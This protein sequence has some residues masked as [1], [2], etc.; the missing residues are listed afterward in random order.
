MISLAS[1]LERIP[2]FFCKAKCLLAYCTT[3]HLPNTYKESKYIF[4]IDIEEQ[5]RIT[6][7]LESFDVEIENKELKIET[8]QRLKNH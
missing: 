3:S 6:M 5:K 8:L 7:K 1:V 2:K 4:P